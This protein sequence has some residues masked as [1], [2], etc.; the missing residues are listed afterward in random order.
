MN[1]LTFQIYRIVVPKF[2]RKRILAKQLPIAILKYYDGI[3][4]PPSEEIQQALNYLKTN[5]IAIFPYDFQNEYHA[6]DIEVFDDREKGMCYVLQDGK[7]LYFKKRWGKRKIRDLYNLLKKEQDI[8]S[9]H[10]YLTDEFRFEEGEVL[11]DVGAA[12]GNLALSV[13]E[14]ASKIIL[15]EANK[16]WIAPLKATF[17]PWK[18][19]VTIV[20]KFVSDVTNETNATLDES[21]SLD[22]SSV[23]LKIDVEGAESR[24]L[25]GAKRILSTHS[26]LK[27]AICTYHKQNDEKEFTKLLSTY[28]F[29][30]SHSDGYMLFYFDKKLKAPYFRRG[31]IRAVK[32]NES[33]ELDQ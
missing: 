3:T 22:G 25:E 16:D 15:F 31:L 6:E 24:L 33:E 4:E 30:T 23:F 27:V 5:P 7:R 26:P 21:L 19:K 11:V 1:R 12:E 29:R 13:V 28:G 10:R 17:E 20:Q 32:M 8:R 18:D 14:K 9:P 2:I